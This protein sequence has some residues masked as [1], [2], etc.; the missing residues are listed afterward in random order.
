MSPVP[1]EAGS[2]SAFVRENGW[3]L[4]GS[5]AAVAIPRRL[6]D[7]WL[8]RALEAPGLRLGGR[9]RLLGLHHLRIGRNLNA[10]NDLWLEAV[11][12]YAGETFD[13]LL[14]IGDDCNLSDG[15]HIA[16]THRVTIG[17]GLLCGSHVLI[18]DHSHGQYSPSAA[19]AQSDPR[20]RPAL[21]PLSR[22]KSI[23]IGANVW[24]GDGVAVLGGARIGDGAVIGVNSV[25]TGEIPPRS[26][27]VGAPARPIRQWDALTASWLP[28][29][30]NIAHR[31]SVA[32]SS[33][34]TTP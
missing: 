29:Q 14:R 27:A 28:W 18:S 7:V 11:T 1:P 5:R 22:D 25:V 8:R 24:L 19:L 17:D 16:C 31:P 30:G 4:L 20:T 2:R 21:R 9:P 10:G 12:A 15:V 26:I 33:A 6:R 13:P 3:F 34:T 32:P 23:N